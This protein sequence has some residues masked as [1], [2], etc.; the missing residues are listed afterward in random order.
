MFDK[1]SF[2]LKKNPLKFT[3]K[4][5]IYN[6]ESIFS[7]SIKCDFAGWYNSEKDIKTQ[8]NFIL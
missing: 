8:L 5:N 1:L 6:D 4:D 7:D 3:F 2:Y